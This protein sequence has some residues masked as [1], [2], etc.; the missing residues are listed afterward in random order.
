MEELDMIVNAL[1]SGDYDQATSDKFVEW[2]PK[3]ELHVPLVDRE[4]KL[5]VEYINEL[6]QAMM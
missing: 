1:V 3:L 5:L 4:H 2:T 6:H